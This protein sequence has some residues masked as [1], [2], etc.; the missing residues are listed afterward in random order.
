MESCISPTAEAQLFLEIIQPTKQ[1]AWEYFNLAMTCRKLGKF[2][3]AIKNLKKAKEI[4]KLRNKF[5][6]ALTSEELSFIYARQ[7]QYQNALKFA[8]EALTIFKEIGYDRGEANSYAS[9]GRIYSRLG[10]FSEAIDY[11]NK[12]A[13]ILIKNDE[14]YLAG[15]AF[16]NLAESYNW[17]REHEKALRCS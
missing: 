6:E 2:E 14:K 11:L 5:T 16:I 12:A 3:E 4:N 13:A 1:K 7:A 15:S 10:K 8:N 9:F 17:K